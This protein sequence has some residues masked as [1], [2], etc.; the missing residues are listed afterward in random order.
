MQ[1]NR[2]NDINE[3]IKKIEKRMAQ[4]KAQKSAIINKEKAKER[5]ERTRRLINNGALAEKY[6]QS[7]KINPK[8]FEVLLSNLVKLGQVKEL[9]YE[10]KEQPKKWSV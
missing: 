8:E 2:E 1:E 3:K 4:L 5:K 9:L 7:E 6:L 10:N